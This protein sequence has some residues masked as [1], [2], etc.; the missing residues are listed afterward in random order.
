MTVFLRRVGKHKA[1]NALAIQETE[2][3]D[4]SKL[5][6]TNNRYENNSLF[7]IRQQRNENV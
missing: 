7:L 4:S 6:Y 5:L 2:E 1:R 3:S